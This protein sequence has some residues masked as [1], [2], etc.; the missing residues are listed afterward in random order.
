MKTLL[1]LLL[2]TFCLLVLVLPVLADGQG[3]DL[4]SDARYAEGTPPMI[5]H[6]VEVDATGDKC[7]ACHL[8]GLHGA[9]LTP[10]A[11]RLDCVQCHGQGEIIEKKHEKRAINKK[12]DGKA[13]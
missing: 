3:D 12:T 2:G 1:R 8:T 7:L 4:E 13:K 10:H 6:R 5:P 11:V 9:P